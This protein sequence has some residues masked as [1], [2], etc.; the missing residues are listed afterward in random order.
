[1]F[2]ITWENDEYCIL[3]I[4][5]YLQLVGLRNVILVRQKETMLKKNVDDND[6]F[7]NLKNN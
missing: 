2:L 7:V 4:R 6:Y 3:V 5:K 1:M